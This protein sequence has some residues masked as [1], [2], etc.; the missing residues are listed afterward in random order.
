MIVLNKKI[1]FTS[2][3]YRSI[4][5]VEV[6]CDGPWRLLRFDVHGAGLKRDAELVVMLLGSLDDQ[7]GSARFLTGTPTPWLVLR[8]SLLFAF[9]LLPPFFSLF[10]QYK[11][12]EFSYCKACCFVNMQI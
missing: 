8:L 3:Q 10:D 5:R 9:E 6:L 4:D 12:S 2:E 1:D 7:R 11:K